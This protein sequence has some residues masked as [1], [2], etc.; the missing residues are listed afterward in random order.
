MS[1]QAQQEIQAEMSLLGGILLYPASLDDVAEV[2]RAEDFAKPAHQA[3]YKA[4]LALSLR[5]E[6]I[7]IVTLADELRKA[8]DL[9]AIGGPVYLSLLDTCVPLTSDIVAHARIVADRA[10]LR[11]VAQTAMEIHRDA[12][13]GQ[14]S[15]QEILDRSGQRMMTACDRDDGDAGPEPIKSILNRVYTELGARYERQADVTGIPSGIEEFDR[16]T[17]GFH[18]GCLYVIAGRPMHGKTSALMGWL[19]HAATE[20]DT[21][22]AMFSL[23]MPKSQLV[24]RV[25]SAEARVPHHR[26]RTGRFEDLDWPRLARASDRIA[27]HSL[28]IDDRAGAT[29]MQIRS[30][31]RR[32]KAKSGL[33]LIAIDYLQLMRGTST[34]HQQTEEQEISEI[35]KGLKEMSKDFAVPVI[36]LAQLNRK[37]EERAD[38]RPMLSDIRSSGSVEQDADLVAFIFRPQVYQAES[39]DPAEIIIAKQRNGA[40]GTIRVAFLEDYMRFENLETERYGR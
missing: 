12:T 10:A 5:S 29:L 15:A 19:V 13:S 9:D 11:R 30:K 17:T 8:G 3:I 16:M 32:V 2:V 28:A 40:T 4:M 26:I 6:V 34:K 33:G 27:R 23:E 18:P 22:I 24:E 1:A 25:L 31:C 21:S 39:K 14:G 38:K 36:A 7:E 37:C 35:S 20:K